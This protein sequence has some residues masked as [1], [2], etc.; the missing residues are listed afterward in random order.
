MLKISFTPCTLH[1]DAFRGTIIHSLRRISIR[2]NRQIHLQCSAK[3][4]SGVEKQYVVKNFIP[5]KIM[6]TIQFLNYIKS[7]LSLLKI[8]ALIK[9]LFFNELLKI[10]LRETNCLY[11]NKFVYK[12]CQLYV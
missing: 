8:M 12:K 1:N 6:A 10:K 7:K 5:F 2:A 4:A 9:L 11:T 3:R